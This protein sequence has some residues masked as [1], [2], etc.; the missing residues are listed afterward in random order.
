MSPAKSAKQY[1]FMAAVASGTARNKPAGLSREEAAEF[2]HKTPAATRSKAMKQLARR[3]RARR[4]K[5]Y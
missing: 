1:R 3:R 4:D 2:V 5:R